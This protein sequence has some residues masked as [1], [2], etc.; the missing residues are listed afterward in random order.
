[1]EGAADRF[2]H[3]G[4]TAGLGGAL[5]VGGLAIA[6]G[7][8]HLGRA[9]GDRQ[10]G[11]G[12]AVDVGRHRADHHVGTLLDEGVV[13]GQADVVGGRVHQQGGGVG[14]VLSVH[15]GHRRLCGDGYRQSGVVLAEV[16]DA[17]LDVVAT[18]AV[19]G[20]GE[21]LHHGVVVGRLAAAGRAVVV[22]V[23]VG[24]AVAAI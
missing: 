14:D 7:L 21:R 24:P 19:G 22:V 16:A 17:D 18:G 23:V 1:M 6:I 10:A 15:I 20:P 12:L 3:R 9:H 4:D 2:G 11:R 5:G 8:G 13:A